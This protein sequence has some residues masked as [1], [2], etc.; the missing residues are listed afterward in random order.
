MKDLTAC[1]WSTI[2]ENHELYSPLEFTCCMFM[3]VHEYECEMESSSEQPSLQDL[4]SGYAFVKHILYPL[5]VFV[6]R[7]KA[8][9][10]SSDENKELVMYS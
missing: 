2:L 1:F 5:M 9:D 8:V 10:I 7:L 6:L 4:S 3:T